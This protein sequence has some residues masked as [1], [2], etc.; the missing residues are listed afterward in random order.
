MR[1]SQL[2]TTG[3]GAPTP[4]PCVGPHTRVLRLTGSLALSRRAPETA[5]EGSGDARAW[6]GKLWSL[7]LCPRRCGGQDESIPGGQ[8]HDQGRHSRKETQMTQEV[9]PVQGRPLR[10][11][12]SP[13][14]T[15][16][17]RARRPIWDWGPRPE[18]PS[19]PGT[20]EGT[21]C[22][23]TPVNAPPPPFWNLPACPGVPRGTPQPAR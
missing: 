6:R 4:A 18:T 16:S 3:C 10:R 5:V 9:C 20:G 17:Q 7:G 11:R 13:P 12:H 15:P 21:Q 2:T 22:S 14:R 19:T 8:N 23:L 1:F